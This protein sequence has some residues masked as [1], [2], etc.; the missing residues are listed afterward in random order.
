MSARLPNPTVGAAAVWDGEFIYFFGG[1]WGGILPRKFDTILRYDTERDNITVMNSS[2]PYGRS[3]LA[4]TVHEKNIYI[5]GGSDG[6]NYSAE[7]FKYLPE[8]DELITLPAKLPS[9]RK[10]VQAE[11]HNG[12][13][14]I[15]G[16]RGAP[17]VVY[18]QIVKFNLKTNEVEIL[19]DKLPRPSEF[20]MHAYD[21]E[22][23]YL[24]GG[25]SAQ[26]DINQFTIFNP[27]V[28]A[29]T[30]S[31]P[32]CP[33]EDQDSQIWI[34]LLILAFVIIITLLMNYRKKKW[35]NNVNINFVKVFYISPKLYKSWRSYYFLFKINLRG[36]SLHDGEVSWSGQR[37]WGTGV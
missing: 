25:F 21:G 33:P 18:H 7:I 28:L 13:I 19:K 34:I 27:D 35:V 32:Y 11:F 29:S 22:S 15:F 20:R 30:D 2:L 6:K 1:S 16:G 37:P 4:A 17:T 5:I 23:I 9:G 26:K 10:H 31:K 24:I 14:Y 8:N 36:Y 3:G 12:S